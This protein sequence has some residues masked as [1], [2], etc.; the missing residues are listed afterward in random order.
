MSPV[1]HLS[2]SERSPIARRIWLL[3]S[4][5]ATVTIFALGGWLTLN[6]WVRRELETVAKKMASRHQVQIDFGATAL[7]PGGLALSG[8]RVATSTGVTGEASINRANLEFALNPFAGN[9]GTLTAITFDRVRLKPATRTAG[10]SSST[11]GNDPLAMLLAPE[12]LTALLED[13]LIKTLE[14]LPS[15]MLMLRARQITLTDADGRTLATASR[16]LLLLDRRQSQVA[17][18]VGELRTDGGTSERGLEGRIARD[19]QGPSLSLLLRAHAGRAVAWSAAATLSRGGNRADVDLS[20]NHPPAFLT[21]RFPGLF[22]PPNRLMGRIKAE[23]LHSGAIWRAAGQFEST[24]TMVSV[25]LVSSTPIGPVDGKGTFRLGFDLDSRELDVES[26]T[27]S[28]PVAA[29]VEDHGDPAAAVNLSASFSAQLAEGD[30]NADDESDGGLL[31]RLSARG[32]IQVPTTPCQSLLSAAPKGLLPA[33]ADFK[34]TGEAGATITF[35]LT[36][37]SPETSRIA[38]ES[39]TFACQVGAAPY[40]YSERRLAAPFT[41]SRRDGDRTITKTLSPVAADFVPLESIGRQVLAAFVAAEDAGFFGHRGIDAGAIATA[42]RRDLSERRL[43]VGGS[44]IT[45]QTVKNLFLGPEKTL[46][47]KGQELVL[48]WYLE[49]VLTKERILELYMNIVELGP[50]VY[51]IAQASEHYFGKHPY[52]LSLS[53]AVFLANLLPAPKT[54]S[55]SFCH[56]RL[57]PGLKDLMAMLL[58]RMVSLGRISR[59]RGYEAMETPI[60]F[61]ESARLTDPDCRTREATNGTATPTVK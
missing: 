30:A 38:L 18:R 42:L 31:S 10:A 11:T 46:A 37:A 35:N 53:E 34:L 12:A 36:S 57:S 43:A 52:E 33:L 19:L 32:Q 1:A 39:S 45:M 47:R 8:I 54:R 50:G 48:A 4:A 9:F 20:L 60:V 28:L 21:Q 2:R 29:A 61:N 22:T 6:Q 44:T 25:P 24:G 51:G 23:V 40:L 16:A 5:A 59:E 56:G 7:T 17:F 15:A 49:Q 55:R 14:H 58:R 3:A 27:L 13:R 41:L 26:L